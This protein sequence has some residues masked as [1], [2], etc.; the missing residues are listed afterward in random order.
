ME[1]YL[2]AWRQRRMLTQRELADAAGVDQGTIVRVER[3]GF[4]PRF[5]TLRKLAAALKIE[6]EALLKEPTDTK[7]AA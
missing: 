3:G 1:V 5:S 6:P 4:T 2:R 7:R